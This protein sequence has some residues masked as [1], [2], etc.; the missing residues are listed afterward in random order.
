ML[1][2]STTTVFKMLVSYT[3]VL[4]VNFLY[5]CVSVEL[6]FKLSMVFISFYIIL[7]L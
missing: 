3:V 6:E 7:Y 1:Y 5:S 4:N 2:A